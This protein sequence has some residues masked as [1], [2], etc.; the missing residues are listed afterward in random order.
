[1]VVAEK[2]CIRYAQQDP[3]P[4]PVNALYNTIVV[5]GRLCVVSSLVGSHLITDL[6]AATLLCRQF[7]TTTLPLLVGVLISTPLMLLVDSQGSLMTSS[8]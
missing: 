8:S 7:Y 4:H 2:R 1:M 5:L 3:C 6:A